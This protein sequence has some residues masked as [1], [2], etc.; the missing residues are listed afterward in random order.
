MKTWNICTMK[1]IL[2]VNKVQR[3]QKTR[4]VIL[5]SCIDRINNVKMSILSNSSLQIQ[6]NLYE[7]I[8]ILCEGTKTCIK[9]CIKSQKIQS[10]QSNLE[11]KN[12]Q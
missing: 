9:I 8:N 4:R 3:T 2:K 12:K 6:C 7:N 1:N 10:S 11:K 5:C